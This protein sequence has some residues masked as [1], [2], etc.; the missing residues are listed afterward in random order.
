LIKE[1]NKTNKITA[2]IVTHNERLASSFPRHLRLS[3]TGITG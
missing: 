2:L 1:V 3:K